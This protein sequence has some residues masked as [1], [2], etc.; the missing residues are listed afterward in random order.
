MR[1]FLIVA[2]LLASAVAAPS[3]A[4]T[5]GQ[6]YGQAPVVTWG[7]SHGRWGGSLTELDGRAYAVTGL[8]ATGHFDG[9]ARAYSDHQYRGDGYGD[10]R[11]Y[12]PPVSHA[13]GYG[14][15]GHDRGGRYGYSTGNRWT[16]WSSPP[17]RGYHDAYGYNDD[18]PPHGA[19]HRRHDRDCNCGVGPY[20]YDR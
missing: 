14:H 13:H 18:R 7:Q 1:E 19:D 11:A 12:R 9:S 20:L 3:A 10:P 15:H 5:W 8:A 16:R 17:G 2:G 4:Q 6:P